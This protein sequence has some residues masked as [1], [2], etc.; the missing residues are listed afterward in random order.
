MFIPRIL[1]EDKYEIK[2]HVN[3]NKKIEYYINKDKTYKHKSK[4]HHSLFHQSKRKKK[5]TFI[6]VPYKP[7]NCGW[8]VDP[9][10]NNNKRSQNTQC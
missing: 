5:K 7:S 1:L 4:T 9:V 8:H 10:P 3:K 6:M 2:S